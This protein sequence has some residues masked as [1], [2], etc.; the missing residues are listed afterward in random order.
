MKKIGVDNHLTFSSGWEWGYWLTDWS[1]ARWSWMH[2][3]NG[4]AKPSHPLSK[5]NDLLPDARIENIWKEA[6][7]LQN[8]YFKERELMPL[9]SALDPSAELPSPFNH[10]FQPRPGFTSEWLLRKSSDDYVNEVLQGPVTSLIEYDQKM[11]RLIKMLNIESA[12]FFSKHSNPELK[13]IMDELTRS[14]QITALRARHRALTLKA[15]IAK[16]EQL[17]KG[18]RTNDTDALLQRAAEVRSE[19]QTI[20]HMQEAGYRYPVELLARKRKSLTAYE[21]GY[22]YPASNLFFWWRE[23]E[24]V[25]NNR[26]DAF[27]LNIWDFK[28]IVGIGSLL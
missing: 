11:S 14:L 7:A 23:E 6:L 15:L 28:R 12:R 9:M 3:E 21:F 22:L 25:R 4:I 5:L 16:R 13:I 27:Y 8:L 2:K 20:V 19:A 10:P 26:F 17:L 24:Q 1:I 18:R